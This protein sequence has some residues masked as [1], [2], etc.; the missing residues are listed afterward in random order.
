MA[1]QVITITIEE[2]SN[3]GV[4]GVDFDCHV[5]AEHEPG[6]YSEK[7]ARCFNDNFKNII[8]FCAAKAA[9]PINK[10]IH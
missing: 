7:I 3:N 6:S 8:D 4:E 10:Q 9:K 2:V 1:K 5:L